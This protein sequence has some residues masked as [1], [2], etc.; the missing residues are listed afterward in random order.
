MAAA[1]LMGAWATHACTANFSQMENTT[2][3]NDFTYSG[4]GQP[5][6]GWLEAVG[7]ISVGE[8]YL[9]EACSIG[10]TYSLN[11]T[12]QLGYMGYAVDGAAVFAAASNVGVQFRVAQ[13]SQ[14]FGSAENV[15]SSGFD[16]SATVPHSGRV[17]IRLWYR[18]VAIADVSSARELKTDPYSW[19]IANFSDAGLTFNKSMV[20][21]TLN[22]Y[23]PPPPPSCSFTRTPPAKVAMPHTT[24]GMLERTGSGPAQA[25]DW[26]F[27]CNYTASGASVTYTPGT[28]SIDPKTGRM[29][30]E[31]GTGAAEGVELEVRRAT[32]AG[33]TKRPVEFNKVLYLGTAGTEYLDVRYVP[34]GA[35]L[36]P[37]LANGSLK[38]NLDVY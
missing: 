21:D 33:A 16:W 9:Y 36:K 14:G 8:V 23:V 26:A 24:I 2:A 29:V 35:T 5:L 10:S 6:T 37:G 19:S 3:S 28:S 1:L 38:V 30:I 22:L 27:S 12:P 15:G 31:P 20:G 11:V 25:F 4:V 17:R 32:S 18:Y 7:S 34:T 13:G